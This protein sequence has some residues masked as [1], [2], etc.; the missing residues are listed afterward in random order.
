MFADFGKR[1]VEFMLQHWGFSIVFILFLLSCLFKL[2]KR[3]I[4]P[5][6]TVISWIGKHLTKDVRKDVETLKTDLD[7]FEKKTTRDM[8][9]MK[10]GT[11]KNCKDL[12]KRLDDMEAAHQKS[13]D[14]QTIQTIRAHILDFANSCFNKRKH[15]KREF[16]NVIEENKLYK[17]L[18]EKYEIENDVYREDYEFI[19]KCYHRCQE[20]G[21]F[22]KEGD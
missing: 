12:K 17:K 9:D 15:T 19:M 14:M 1:L 3:E 5:L 2:T 8:D 10:K 21:T 18:V 6:G 20:E 11:D 7:N 4:D 13:N 22:L 16:E